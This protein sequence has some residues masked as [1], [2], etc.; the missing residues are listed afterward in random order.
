M[1]QIVSFFFCGLF[2]KHTNTATEVQ[3]ENTVQEAWFGKASNLQQYFALLLLLLLLLL[4]AIKFSLG[5]SNPYT[6]TDKR[7]KNK[8]P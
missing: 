4:I 7:N 8:Y 3:A 1:K 5:G 2:C 6:S